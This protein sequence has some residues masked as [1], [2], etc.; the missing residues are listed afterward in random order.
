MS[1]FTPIDLSVYPV[2]DV[3]E[4]L[5][6]EAYLARDTAEFA[7]RWEARRAVRPELPP[8]SAFDIEA[9]PLNTGAAG[10][11][12]PRDAATRPRQ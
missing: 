4:T 10:R 3:L 2:A 11:Q 7:A 8:F 12:L 9:S 1:R 5:G 6:F